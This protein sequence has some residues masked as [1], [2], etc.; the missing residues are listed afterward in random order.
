MVGA[1]LGSGG[2]SKPRPYD[3]E[4][5]AELR[6]GGAIGYERDGHSRSGRS[7]RRPYGTFE[8]TLA[9]LVM[10][11]HVGE[12]AV[13]WEKN[14]GWQ[15]FETQGEPALLGWRC[16]AFLAALDSRGIS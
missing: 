8:L 14:A 9:E 16:G 4:A 10:S 2:R 1:S 11:L 6:K 13:D 12:A 15:P 7:K 5:N 3:R